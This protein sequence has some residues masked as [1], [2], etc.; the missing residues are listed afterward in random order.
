MPRD[1]PTFLTLPLELRLE[2]YT[3]L[4]VLPPP[5]PPEKQQPIY[6]CSHA[7]SPTS[8]EKATIHTQILLVNHQTNREATP[9]L[10]TLNTFTAHPTLLT[11]APTLRHHAVYRWP[12]TKPIR[13]SKWTKLIRKWHLRVRVDSAAPPPWD[14]GQVAAA[15]SHAEELTLDLWSGTLSVGMESVGAGGGADVL[16]LFEGVRGVRRVRIAGMVAGLEGHAK[17]LTGKM[18]SMEQEEGQQGERE[19][20]GG[21]MEGGRLA[22]LA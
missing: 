17:C 4:L 16:R 13:N 5:P 6:R 7:C 21:E 15:F 9:L 19:R 14:R 12:S 10:Y 3:H 8:E 11:A 18:M 20:E 22:A 2:I 1:R